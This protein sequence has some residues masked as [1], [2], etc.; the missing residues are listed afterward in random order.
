MILVLGSIAARS[1]IEVGGI[2]VGGAHTEAREIPGHDGA[3]GTVDRSRAYHVRAR[4]E[5][6]EVC[7]ADCSHTRAGRDAFTATFQLRNA[8]FQG[9]NRRVPQASV[10]VSIL[11]AGEQ[12][13]AMSSIPET[14]G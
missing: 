10:D 5:K 1:D 2:D 7:G 4:P 12:R 9:M 14:E 3:A 8:F 13:S 11:F 6:S